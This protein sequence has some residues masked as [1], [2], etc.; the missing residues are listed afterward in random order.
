MRWL[1]IATLLLL[2]SCG[3]TEPAPIASPNTYR[4]ESVALRIG[5]TADT[6][7]AAYVASSFFSEAKAEPKL[8]R[9]FVPEDFGDGSKHVA[10]FSDRLWKRRFG[11]DPALIGRTVQLDGQDHTVVGI[12]PQNFAFPPNVE[13]WIPM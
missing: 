7:P 5:D 9:L 8:G 10:V 2:G 13:I 6:I 4:I 12:M 11:A 3:Q 1:L